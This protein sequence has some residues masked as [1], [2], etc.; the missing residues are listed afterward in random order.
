[1]Y[2]SNKKNTFGNPI[3][4]VYVV[5]NK[6]TERDSNRVYLNDLINNGFEVLVIDISYIIYGKAVF[7]LDVKAIINN[8][9]ECKSL[10]EFYKL[11]N[12]F[13]PDFSVNFV[14][15]AKSKYLIR[16]SIALFLCN[17]SRLIEYYCENIPLDTPLFSYKTVIKKIFFLP[18]IFYKPAYSIVT[19][20]RS[21]KLAKGKLI[22]LHENDYDLYL[23]ALMLKPEYTSEPYLLFLDEGGPF[24]PDFVFQKIKCPLTSEIYYP[25]INESLFRL[26]ANLKLKPIVQL[27]PK[28]D[29]NH[30]KNFFQFEISQMP[31]IDAIR[32][33]SLIVA[34]SSTAIQ[35]AVIFQ[36]PIILLKTH[37]LLEYSNSKLLIKNFAKRLNCLCIWVDESSKIHSIPIV[38][39]DAYKAYQNEFTKIPDT[40]DKLN[41]QLFIDF[42]TNE[43]LINSLT[44]K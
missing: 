39:I 11:V 27:H 10:N 34:H 21:I 7:S 6:F 20:Q 44:I 42:L 30:V 24:H 4:I 26:A 33:A 32:G 16:L 1:M 17:K 19:N 3:R 38:D 5:E 29:S 12:D 22:K 36:K 25:E 14:H 31:S 41:G 18:W 28:V 15:R 9:I 2:S 8:Y 13:K 37:Q 35:M 43:I 23:K 40:D